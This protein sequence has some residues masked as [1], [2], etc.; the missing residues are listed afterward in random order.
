MDLFPFL[1]YLLSQIILQGASLHPHIF[2]AQRE[3]ILEEEFKDYGLGV[4]G[5]TEAED[6]LRRHQDSRSCRKAKAS[7]A[8]VDHK[9]RCDLKKIVR[10]PKQTFCPPISPPSTTYY[11]HAWT[12]KAT[13]V[14]G[15]TVLH[16]NESFSS[17]AVNFNPST[18]PMPSHITEARQSDRDHTS[19]PWKDFWNP[20]EAPGSQ[21]KTPCGTTTFKSADLH[22]PDS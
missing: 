2:H 7:R 1:N 4:G 17:S 11:T 9:H 12:H 14:P 15:V 22:D 16:S 19:N 13:L 5:Y 8:E 18:S 21:T 6:P 20:T 10:K 3:K